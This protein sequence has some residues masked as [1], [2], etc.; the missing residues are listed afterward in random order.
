MAKI[1]KACHFSPWRV[2]FP[3][4]F[5]SIEA[6]MTKL[7][8][9][10]FPISYA[11]IFQ[12]IGRLQ[13]MDTTHFLSSQ[14]AITPE[15]LSDPHTTLNGLQLLTLLRLLNTFVSQ[16][17]THQQTL[18]DVFPPT[19]HGHV[20]LAAITASTVKQA[21][22]VAVR[23]AHQ[24]M[25]AF[26]ISYRVE[27]EQCQIGFVRLADFD[28]CNELMTEMIFCA[29]HSF[30]RMF[31]QQYP[32]IHLTLQHATLTLSELPHLYRYLNIRMGGSENLIVFPHHLLDHQ[33][34]TR[35]EATYQAIANV[36]EAHEAHLV[37]KGSMTDQVKR[38]I[39]S[40]LTHQVTVTANDI[41]QQLALS[42]RTL[43]RRLADENT[44]LRNLYN[45]CRCHVA[46]DLLAHS[47]MS[48]GG[49]GL[50]LGFSDE[51]NFSR[52]FKQQTGKPPTL[53]RALKQ[54]V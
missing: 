36:L 29:L 50:Q 30:L 51:A 22:D 3:S 37:Q 35:N 45:E 38:T 54:H 4:P 8:D 47:S 20:A 21:L 16:D 11:Q 43:S 33:I 17:K 10:S 48:I 5:H 1:A 12:E 49:I 25:P 34:V 41:A 19:I 13:G 27:G 52:F 31:G 28:E 6:L 46:K 15:Q 2:I 40:A 18:I 9:L 53:Y 39:F 26:K 24:V 23:F 7:E 42:H 44:N 14:L 32:L